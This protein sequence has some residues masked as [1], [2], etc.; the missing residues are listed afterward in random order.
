MKHF[1]N[2]SMLSLSIFL[3][4]LVAIGCGKSDGTIDKTFGGSDY[5]EGNF[6][7]QTSDDGFILTG[8]TESYGAGRSDLWLLKLTNQGDI[9][10]EKTFGDTDHDAGSSVIETIDAGFIALGWTQSFGRGDRN[11]WLIK[12]D[13]KGNEQW[14]KTYG[15]IGFN[16]GAYISQTNY[17]N[18]LITGRISTNNSE[19]TEG[20]DIFV[21][22]INRNGGLI[23]SNTYGGDHS[24]SDDTGIIVKVLSDGDLILVGVLYDYLSNE[25]KGLII[26]L[27]KDGNTLWE[28]QVE[29]I[30]PRDI[31]MDSNGRFLIS[32]NINDDFFILELDDK[33]ETQNLSV[34]K[35][36]S[37]ERGG[38]IWKMNDNG[39]LLVGSTDGSGRGKFD[40]VII[41]TDSLYKELW[42][43]SFGGSA[44]DEIKSGVLTKSG[45]L[46][47]TGYT[48]SKGSGK[49]DLWFLKI[50][51]K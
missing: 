15:S 49:R 20:S 14:N 19:S 34:F 50:P 32:G 17:G 18:F 31:F 30:W 1:R 40:A 13:S 5:D 29:K 39:Y 42:T 38:N 7:S 44:R 41:R 26:K 33:G 46:A 12:T 21:M 11:I 25:T 48:E 9:E 51:I 16:E 10:W 47:V 6:I 28:R 24:L 27:D 35:S 3:L 22:M 4:L 36:D 45:Y 8:S 2:K 37:K 43:K 23:W